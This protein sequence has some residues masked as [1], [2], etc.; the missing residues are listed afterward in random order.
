MYL[1]LLKIIINIQQLYNK[2]IVIIN[3]IKLHFINETNLLF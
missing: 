2:F 1:L 3:S